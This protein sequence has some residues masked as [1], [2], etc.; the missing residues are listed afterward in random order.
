MPPKPAESAAAAPYLS[1]ARRFG[2][3]IM[4]SSR[5]QLRSE[6]TFRRTRHRARAEISLYSD[7]DFIFERQGTLKAP[8][9][10]YVKV[11]ETYQR[12]LGSSEAS[13]AEIQ[14][15]CEES[16]ASTH[17][18]STG[19]RRADHCCGYSVLSDE[20]GAGRENYFICR[21]HYGTRRRIGRGARRI[22]DTQRGNLPQ[23][24]NDPA[25]AD[26][27]GEALDQ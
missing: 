12:A 8:D 4:D 6:S 18:H 23:V 14:Y 27:F 26:E 16:C 5:I 13:S 22:C 9:M 19:T 21:G 25:P 2:R 11:P 15:R 3:S 10:Q 24:G 1:T 20:S 17:S 7:F